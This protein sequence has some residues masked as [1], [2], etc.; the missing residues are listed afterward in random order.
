MPLSVF[1]RKQGFFSKYTGG[2][3]MAR[4]PGMVGYK[5]SLREGIS[6]DFLKKLVVIVALVGFGASV[7]AV[8][9]EQLAQIKELV[10]KYKYGCARSCLFPTLGGDAEFTFDPQEP[11]IRN[12]ATT[13]AARILARINAAYTE[14]CIAR[15]SRENVHTGHA[16]YSDVQ[17]Y[18]ANCALVARYD[19]VAVAD[20]IVAEEF[21]ELETS[22]EEA[23]EEADPR[24]CVIS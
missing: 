5:N 2:G 10:N 16:S 24:A 6:M 22:V 13:E 20:A 8:T 3:E 15:Q 4:G 11:V 23:Y 21:A 19:Y 1:A 9:P 18:A 7:H 14:M 12:T 17:D